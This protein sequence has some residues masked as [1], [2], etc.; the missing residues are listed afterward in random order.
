M[1]KK[2]KRAAQKARAAA[3]AQDGEEE[4]TK[5][6]Q[7]QAKAPSKDSKDEVKTVELEEDDTVKP[8]TNG[9]KKAAPGK[10]KGKA[11]KDD[12]S[13]ADANDDEENEDSEN[14]DPKGKGKQKIKNKTQKRPAQFTDLVAA[15]TSAGSGSEFT[16]KSDNLSLGF[17]GKSLLENTS[18]TLAFGRRYGLVG[19]N[20]SG[21]S[22]LLRAIAKREIPGIPKD[23]QILHVE[24]E[25]EGDDRT[26]LQSVIDAD[27]ERLNLLKERDELEAFMKDI[28]KD[29]EE[30]D[31]QKEQEATAKRERLTEVYK[32]LTQIGAHNA[33][34]R[35]SAILTG[36]QF[37]DRMKVGLRVPYQSYF[38]PYE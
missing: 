34:S 24:Q 6:T 25:V 33:E 8:V 9:T 17:Q 21:K 36:L 31:E 18:L 19:I 1:P 22:T 16:L 5:T 29:D 15:A 12:D 4:Q 20:G 13:D 32:L 11:Q 3:Q 28:G 7:K 2:G 26:P 27:V 35:A 14:E 37:T 10:G 23:I 30:Y 38:F